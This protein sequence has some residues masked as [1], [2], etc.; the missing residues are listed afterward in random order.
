MCDFREFSITNMTGSYRRVFQKPVD[1]EWYAPLFCK[2]KVTLTSDDIVHI[3][4]VFFCYAG[5]YS[6]IQ[7]VTYR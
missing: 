1:F 6:H 2:M 5:N 7:M 4:F 3:S